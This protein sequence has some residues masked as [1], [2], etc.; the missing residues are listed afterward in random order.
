MEEERKDQGL[1]PADDEQA[2]KP[3]EGEPET[4]EEEKEQEIEQAQEKEPAEEEREEKEKKRKKKKS[5]QERIDELVKK[6][7]NAER[8]AQFY[9]SLYEETQKQM[10][11]TGE[12]PAIEGKPKPEDFESYE[13]YIEAL[14]DWKLQQRFSELE[15]QRRL[16]QEQRRLMELQTEFRARLPEFKK[17]Y[18]DFEEVALNPTIPYNDVMRRI[19]LESDVSGDLAY[20]LGRNPDLAYR[21]ANS[22]PVSAA[23][24]LGRIEAAIKAASENK[25]ASSPPVINPVKTGER[26]GSKKPDDMSMEEYIR[27]RQKQAQEEI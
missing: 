13:E 12:K 24:E 26:S 18:P 20:Y 7:R 23:R 6:W 15:Q 19:V 9:K 17:K 1:V 16:E 10:T 5:F 11:T 3:A 27:W 22:D 25:S 2:E 21:I 14:T 4:L 8:E